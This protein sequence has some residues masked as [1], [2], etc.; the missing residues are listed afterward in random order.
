MKKYAKYFL[1]NGLV[2]ELADKIEANDDFVKTTK[3]VKPTEDN[4]PTEMLV[5]GK[6]PMVCIDNTPFD[7]RQYG[8]LEYETDGKNI[9]SVTVEGDIKNVSV[10]MSNIALDFSRNNLFLGKFI[11]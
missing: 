8:I 11:S 5:D 10:S 1:N 3:F 9:T 7:K 6:I 2:F 4:I